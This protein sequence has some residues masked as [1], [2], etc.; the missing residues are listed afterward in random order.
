MDKCKLNIDD[1]VQ[2]LYGL[3]SP[4]SNTMFILD[5]SLI[6]TFIYD[7]S[8]FVFSLRPTRRIGKLSLKIVL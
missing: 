4:M 2:N 3:Q 1:M 6:F 7:V 8:V 5:D